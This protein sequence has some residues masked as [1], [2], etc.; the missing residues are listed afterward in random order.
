MT[1]Q[2]PLFLR[3]WTRRGLLVAGAGL[4]A[5]LGLSARVHASNPPM[6]AMEAMDAEVR[7]EVE[8]AA[9]F[10]LESPDPELRVAFEHL[11]TDPYD[12]EAFV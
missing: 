5:G 7:E 1:D 3:P 2:V 11:Y 8:A 9:K 10:A 4:A 12:V 6:E